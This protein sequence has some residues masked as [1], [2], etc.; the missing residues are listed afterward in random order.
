M[1]EK[2]K[3]SMQHR[4]LAH[5][6]ANYSDFTLSLIEGLPLRRSSHE[7]AWVVNPNFVSGLELSWLVFMVIPAAGRLVVCRCHRTRVLAFPSL[8]TTGHILGYCCCFTY[9]SFMFSSLPAYLRA[10]IYSKH[11]WCV[12][13]RWRCLVAC[14]WLWISW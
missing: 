14:S 3:S 10:E 1:A 12:R 4:Q 9:H 13:M 2:K 11:W 6:A 7:T 8:W 5:N